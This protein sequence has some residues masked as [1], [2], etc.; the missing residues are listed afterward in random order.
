MTVAQTVAQVPLHCA[1]C[2][3]QWSDHE[4]VDDHHHRLSQA[5]LG[6]L[7]GTEMDALIRLTTRHNKGLLAPRLPSPRERQ[8]IRLA[9]GVTQQQVA[10]AL[11][12]SRHTVAKW[13]KAAG[14]LYG[15][16]LAGREPVGD[17]RREYGR[18]L[19]NLQALSRR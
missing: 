10:D 12:V 17:L 13:E 2:G 16:R 18:V 5:D 1:I 3:T 11:M 9:A 6:R 8:E 14:Y 19:R 7:T 15:Q 4:T